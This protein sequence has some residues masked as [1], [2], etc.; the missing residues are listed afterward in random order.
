MEY[1]NVKHYKRVSSP[2]VVVLQ[3]VESSQEVDLS[4]N[5]INTPE[6]SSSPK[7]GIMGITNSFRLFSEGS[8]IVDGTDETF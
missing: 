6:R 5:L 7:A 1:S 3:E 4:Q 8:G 2:A